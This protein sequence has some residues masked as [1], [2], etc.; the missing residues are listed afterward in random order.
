MGACSSVSVVV[1]LNLVVH[2]AVSSPQS[3]RTAVWASNRL[4]FECLG[5]VRKL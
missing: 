2:R 3:V 5:L 1:V 4:V